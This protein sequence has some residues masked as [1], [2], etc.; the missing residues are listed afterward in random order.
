QVQGRE[1]CD[2]APEMAQMRALG[3]SVLRLYP[4]ADGM[5]EVVQY[6]RAALASE[7]PLPRRGDDNGYWHGRAGMAV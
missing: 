3:A 5:A 2:L 1:V 7:S 4:Q 6:F